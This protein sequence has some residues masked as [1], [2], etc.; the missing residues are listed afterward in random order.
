MQGRARLSLLRRIHERRVLRPR[1]TQPNHVFVVPLIQLSWSTTIT[2]QFETR[3]AQPVETKPLD[4]RHISWSSIIFGALFALALSAMLHLLAIGVTAS[5]SGNAN[6]A[7][8]DMVKIGGASALLFIVATV[9]SL[10]IGG[11]VASSLAKTFSAGRAMTYGLGVWTLTTLIVLAVTVP[12]FL[13]TAGNA[14]STAG[15]VIDRTG[16]ALGQAA[17]QNSLFRQ[18]QTTLLGTDVSQ[19]DQGAAQ[20]IARLIGLRVTQG[21]WTQQQRDQLASDVARAAKI[22]QDDA[23]RRVTEA[24]NTIADTVRKGAKTTRKTVEGTAY[25]FFT[26]MLVGM[27]AALIGAYFGEMVLPSRACAFRGPAKT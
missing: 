1:L 20:D 6:P 26:T 12:A 9:I 4:W 27:I 7:S 23:R 21:N 10:F 24:E 15:T 14:A 19:V 25:A 8:S 22:S 5:I 3:P 2:D 11:F 17:D 18:A 16:N 13:R